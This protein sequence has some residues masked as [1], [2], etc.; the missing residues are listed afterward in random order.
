MKKLLVTLLSF[1]LSL[2][3]FQINVSAEEEKTY[4]GITDVQEVILYS[5]TSEALEIKQIVPPKST[6][7]I[8]GEIFNDSNHPWLNI[9]FK[10]QTGWIKDANITPTNIHNYYF[11]SISPKVS[12]RKGASLSYQTASSLKKGELFKVIDTFTTLSGENWVRVEHGKTKGWIPI[13]E[14]ELFE[15]DKNYLNIALLINKETLVKRSATHQAKKVYT[16]RTGSQVTIQS[17]LQSPDGTWY[18]IRDGNKSGWILAQDASNQ[19]FY[20]STSYVKEGNTK[21]YK[22]ATA[23]YKVAA[24]L[25]SGQQVQ[26]LYK[27]VNSAN[28]VWVKIIFGNQKEG[29]V[30]A[31]S[32]TSKKL[33]VAY[34][35][36]DDGPTSQTGKLLDILDTY[37]AKATFFM[38][39]G[40][41]NQYSKDVKRMVQEGHSVGSHSVT[42]DKNKFYKSSQSAVNEMVQNRNTIAKVTGINS[43]LM[44]TPYGSVPYMTK[45][46][47]AAMTKQKFIMWDWNIDS[48]DWKYNSDKFVTHTMNQVSKIEKSGGTPYILIHDR[49]ATIDHLPKLVRAL[50]ASGYTL[51]PIDENMVPYQFASR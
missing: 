19:V 24:T 49:K 18:Q 1:L 23:S 22:G 38:L 46:Y 8:L 25:P 47:R 4:I 27:F 39:N 7:I 37:N 13:S 5:G 32:L 26:T 34:L 45:S 50:Q 2:V 48:L 11:T 9:R 31:D 21:V 3:I 33:K 14:L 43:N 40:Q 28:E 36:I 12:I 10:Q 51:A 42:H 17:S 15:G 41:I 29:W 20:E 44:R 16:L 35:T 30:K 6:V